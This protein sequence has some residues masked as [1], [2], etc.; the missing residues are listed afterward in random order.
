M[1][2][3][4][5]SIK[6]ARGLETTAEPRLQLLAFPVSV[7]FRFLMTSVFILMVLEVLRKSRFINDLTSTTVVWPTK[8]QSVH[9]AVLVLIALISL[10][11]STRYM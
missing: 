6:T 3:H 4:K 9:R 7:F 11:V 10:T 1:Q 2:A 5:A 8:K